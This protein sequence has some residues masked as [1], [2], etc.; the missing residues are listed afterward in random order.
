MKNLFI[1][2]LAG[3]LAT[4]V[5]A[6]IYQIVAWFAYGFNESA[7]V[8]ADMLKFWL[9]KGTVGIVYSVVFMLFYCLPVFLLLA[10]FNYAN[11]L[12]VTIA[13]ILPIQYCR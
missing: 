6:A 2:I 13:A 8:F 12:L 1:G 7:M 5:A 4:P 10:K 3:V 11:K 9:I